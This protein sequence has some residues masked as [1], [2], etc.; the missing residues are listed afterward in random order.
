MNDP[1]P[2]QPRPRELGNG[3]GPRQYS[4]QN[5]AQPPKLSLDPR[6]PPGPSRARRSSPTFPSQTC[7][8][9]HVPRRHQGCRL[10]PLVPFKSRGPP[11]SRPLHALSERVNREPTLRGAGR[12]NGARAEGACAARSREG[13]QG[14]HR[15]VPGGGEEA[16]LD[17]GRGPSGRG[18]LPRWVPG[19]PRQERAP[20]RTPGSRWRA[21]RREMGLVR[22]ARQP[23]RGGSTG[24]SGADEPVPWLARGFPA[25][26]Y[27]PSPFSGRALHG[28]T[29]AW[30]GGLRGG[31]GRR[32]WCPPPEAAGAGKSSSPSCAKDL[33]GALKLK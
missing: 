21:A 28:R 8:G 13:Q 16:R 3:G 23:F 9:P 2:L 1:G 18:P 31:A 17:P 15:P 20:A 10:P 11:G 30:S 26:F 24:R 12:T 32:E 25:R 22:G 4:A 14:P 29:T 19:S 33:E 6:G 5:V 7:L 27:L